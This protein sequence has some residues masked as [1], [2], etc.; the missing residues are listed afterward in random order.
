MAL[1]LCARPTR[2]VAS[3]RAT[4]AHSPAD[5]RGGFARR[6]ELN[7]NA[8][9]KFDESLSRRDIPVIARRFN[10]GLVVDRIRVP[11]G[12]LNGYPSAPSFNRPFGTCPAVACIPALKRWAIF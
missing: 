8:V 12:R 4:V 10:A 9:R 6:R 11:K 5:V 3:T 2:L 1:V 7:P